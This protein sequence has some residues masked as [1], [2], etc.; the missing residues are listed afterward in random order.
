MD[1]IEILNKLKTNGYKP[2]NSKEEEFIYSLKTNGFVFFDRET[3]LF[4]LQP[5]T[6]IEDDVEEVRLALNAKVQSLGL[7]ALNNNFRPSL[8]K[9]VHEPFVQLNYL[10]LMPEVDW[11]KVLG[12]HA[13]GETVDCVVV[14]YAKS[15]NNEAYQVELPASIKSLHYCKNKRADNPYFTVS[16]SR[17]GKERDSSLLD[18]TP[19]RRTL[20]KMKLGVKTSQ[21]V[22]FSKE[23]IQGAGIKMTI[24]KASFYA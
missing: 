14:G 22:L 18:F 20:C 9:V 21:G 15:N 16:L 5:D 7:F 3:S 24:N 23:Q 13:L 8:E 1:G 11:A 12:E 4:K 10:G 6:I 17:R 19:I 2:E